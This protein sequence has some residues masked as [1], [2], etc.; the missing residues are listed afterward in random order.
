MKRREKRTS[1]LWMGSMRRHY[2]SVSALQ[3][4]PDMPSSVE[5]RSICRANRAVCFQKLVWCSFILLM[6]IAFVS[7]FPYYAHV[8]HMSYLTQFLFFVSFCFNFFLLNLLRSLCLVVYFGCRQFY[9][10][11]VLVIWNYQLHK[12]K[13][14]SKNFYLQ[15]ALSTFHPLL[16]HGLI[17]HF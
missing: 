13:I 5:I 9:V 12:M 2:H 6:R 16:L 7:T 15:Y 4:A 3:V 8:N 14:I 11:L 10:R 17:T 1:F